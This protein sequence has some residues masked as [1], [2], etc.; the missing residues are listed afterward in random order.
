MSLSSYVESGKSSVSRE[1][2]SLLGLRV[3]DAD[4]DVLER[5]WGQSVADKLKQ[6][7]D[8]AFLRAEAAELS[9]VQAE[10][11]VISLSGSGSRRA[12]GTAA[13]PTSARG[14]H[15]H[16]HGWLRVNQH[17]CSVLI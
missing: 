12:T 10:N 13:A 16:G 4:D 7:G 3:L 14:R 5:N 1:L 2:G 8:E 6:L 11:T 17:I 15:R 9:T